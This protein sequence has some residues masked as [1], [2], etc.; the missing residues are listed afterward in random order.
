MT[1]P[2][3]HVGLGLGLLSD[4]LDAA[5][6]DVLEA[7]IDKLTD[8]PLN[9][10]LERAIGMD[11]ETLKHYLT[12]PEEVFDEVMNSGLSGQRVTLAEFNSD[13]LRA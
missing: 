12:D 9:Y 11:K 3:D 13:F 8:A 10:V 2:P 7:E 4:I 1:G 5:I 6:P